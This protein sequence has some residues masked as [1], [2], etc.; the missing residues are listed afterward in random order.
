MLPIKL[1]PDIEDRFA[2]KNAR[3]H[4]RTRGGG[5]RAV[6]E[7]PGRRAAPIPG[8]VKK[9]LPGLANIRLNG[10]PRCERVPATVNAEYK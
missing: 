4:A 2:T 7:A 3:T 9:G 1:H 5:G 8:N 6:S 10:I